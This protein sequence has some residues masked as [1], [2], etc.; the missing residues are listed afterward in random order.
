[1]DSTTSID[2][3]DELL[4]S[5]N[6]ISTPPINILTSINYQTSENISQNISQNIKTELLNINI[7]NY[8]KYNELLNSYKMI[9][10]IYNELK[11]KQQQ[12]VKHIKYLLDKQNEA[13]KLFLELSKKKFN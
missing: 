1:M 8:K 10:E 4:L 9:E 5:A 7:E 6:K 13:N 11:D 12:Y 2:N 3:L